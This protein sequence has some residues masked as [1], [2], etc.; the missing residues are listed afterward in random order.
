MQ[1][2]FLLPG[3]FLI[4]L[5]GE[6][7]LPNVKFRQAYHRWDWILNIIGFVTQGL[8]VPLCGYLIALKLLPL[9]WPTGKGILP[10]GWCSAFLINFIGVDF[11]YY[12]QHRLFH[13]LPW[14][15]Q[16]HRCHHASPRVDIWATS[17]NTILTN[18]FFVYLL[19]NPWLAFL[20]QSPEGFFA[21][22]TLTAGLDLMRHTSINFVRIPTLR[23]LTN[24]L[25][26]IL[27]M[28]RAHHRHHD[29]TAPAANF[30]ANLILWDKLFGTLCKKPHSEN[31]QAH[32]APAP[33]QQ[34]LYPLKKH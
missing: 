4:L 13:E 14:A 1:W 34:L 20:C 19:I 22:A 6:I 17:R 16:W 29:A 9:L 15:W 23:T 3:F 7:L 26:K 33:L 25:E 2:C 27:I 28:P 5:A 30:G 12:W 24:F 31:Y 21:G 8:L 10:L 18:L 11:L 32:D